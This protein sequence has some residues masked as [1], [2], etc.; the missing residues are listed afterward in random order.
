MK[1]SRLGMA[2][3]VALALVVSACGG[4]GNPSTNE[5]G[6]GGDAAEKV[7][8]TLLNSKSEIQQQM[9]NAAAAFMASNPGIELEVITAAESQS[10]VERASSLYAAGTPATLA[11]LDAGD[12]AKFQDKAADL[13]GEKWVA[14]LAQPNQIDGK[15][16]AFPFAIEG[17][18]LIYNKAVL[19]KAVGGAFDPA[20][21]KTTSALKDL[22]AKIEATGVAPM[23]I[24]SMDWSLGNHYLAI[25]YATQ[26]EGDVNA[27]LAQL[28]SGGANLANNAV[29]NGLLDTFDVLK[30]YN[31]GKDDPIAIVLERSAAAVASGEAAMTFNGN[32]LIT[33]MQKTNPE[34]DF[35][36]IPVPVSDDAGNPANASLAIGAT[37]QIFIDK[38]ASTEAQQAAAKAFLNWLVYEEAG[39]N[40]LVNE[41]NVIPAFKNIT[42]ELSNP[43]AKSLQAYNNAGHAIPFA[44][45]YV[46][47]DHW[48]VLG[49]SMQKYLV[50][51]ADRAALAAEIEEYW[52]SVK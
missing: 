32:W 24:G 13:S 6:A 52:K 7:K 46:P 23:V 4:N 14:D 11:M 26:P 43:L 41:A 47:G 20:S 10:P 51:K 40:F 12:I 8:I 5:G 34:G 35:G 38:E 33:E 21:I 9:T 1:R 36:F 42:L 28:K 3:L 2:A 15:T 50:D 22:M 49:A 16:I 39:Q 19:D 29:F 37:K 45:N 18:G 31:L 44:G 25:A 17:T 48:K 30:Q 27:F